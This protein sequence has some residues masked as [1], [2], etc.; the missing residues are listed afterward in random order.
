MKQTI[1]FESLTD[2][3]PNPFYLNKA[4]IIS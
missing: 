3:N 2:C 1:R 4:T